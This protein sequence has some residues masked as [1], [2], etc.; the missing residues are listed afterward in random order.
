MYVHKAPAAYPHAGTLTVGK[1]VQWWRR[2]RRRS[3]S[4]ED[5]DEAC[6]SL[7]NAV[8]GSRCNERALV[9][10]SVKWDMTCDTRNS[11]RPRP[12]AAVEG[13]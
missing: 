2:R 6:C 12:M 4:Q 3:P 5:G 13:V 11:R 1:Y 8:G 10:E 7:S 9:I